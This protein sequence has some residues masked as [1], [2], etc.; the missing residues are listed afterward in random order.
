MSKKPDWLGDGGEGRRFQLCLVGELSVLE[1]L[2]LELPPGEV[3]GL[4]GG[5]NRIL[6]GDRSWRIFGGEGGLGGE[7]LPC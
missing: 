3:G 2:A 4:G 7:A 1:E 5:E 6:C